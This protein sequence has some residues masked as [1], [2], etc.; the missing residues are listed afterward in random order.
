M[1]SVSPSRRLL[2]HLVPY[3]RAYVKG[4]LGVVADLRASSQGVTAVSLTDEKVPFP[5][6][7]VIARAYPHK[8]VGI[9]FEWTGFKMPG[10]IADRLTDSDNGDAHLSD[11]DA[12][13]TGSITRYFGIQGGYRKVSADYVLDCNTGDLEMKGFY[14]GGMVRF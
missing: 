12:Y 3:R 6:L 4:F 1:K 5:A 9:T 14:F 10:F 13:V 7:G 2:E 11:F 8:N